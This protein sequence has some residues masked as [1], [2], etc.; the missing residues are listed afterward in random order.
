METLKISKNSFN[1]LVD[2]RIGSGETV[3]GVIKKG[4]KFAFAEL[5]S[6]DQLRLDY[7]ITILP[8]KKYFLPSEEPVLS[9]KMKDAGSY[10]S[11]INN[12]TRVV[13]GVHPY[14]L[15]GIHILDTAFM[16]DK[17]DQN[18]TVRRNNTTLIGLYPV[19]EFE[20]RFASSADNMDPKDTSD[21][22]LCDLGDYFGVE[23]F[24][25]K[26]KAFFNGKAEE[27]DKIGSEIEAKKNNIPDAQKL[28]LSAADIPEFLEKMQDSEV[29]ENRGAKCFSCGSCVFVCPTCYCFNM[30][31]ELDLS[32]EKGN[33]VRVWDGCMLE[34][35]AEVA[36]GHNFR[37][38]KAARFRHRLFRKGKYLADRL[39]V[40]GCVGCGRCADACT[41]DIA[42]P[43]EIIADLKKES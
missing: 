34:G 15:T 41:A 40:F 28:P 31:E 17:T 12:D 30:K 2:T 9:F 10:K 19:K 20:Y 26:G 4:T 37:E 23:V 24:S 43:V 25:D 29:W 33:R 21:A 16:E 6:S 7:D 32:L 1:S 38:Q 14:D 27:D 8:P 13:I 3:I 42:N 35:F 39:G 11:E 18:Y 36:G 22:M 5:D